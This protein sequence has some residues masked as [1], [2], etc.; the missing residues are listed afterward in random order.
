MT[1]IA[2][3]CVGLCRCIL[4]LMMDAEHNTDECK[5]LKRAI[6]TIQAFLEALP[7]TG[8]P[9]AGINAISR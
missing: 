2:L 6:D 1:D 4:Q 7:E 3:P 5:C 8:L 9:D